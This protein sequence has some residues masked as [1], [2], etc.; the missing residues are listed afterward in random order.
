MRG[1]DED[2]ELPSTVKPIKKSKEEAEEE[3]EQ[4]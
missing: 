1:E 3:E 2:G 4:N